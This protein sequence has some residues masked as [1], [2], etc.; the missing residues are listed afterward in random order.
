MDKSAHQRTAELPYSDRQRLVDSLVPYFLAGL[1]NNEPCLWVAA[2]PLDTEDA[3]G[4][5][6]IFDFDE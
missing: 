1:R 3:R 5:L 6:R 2:P 4:A